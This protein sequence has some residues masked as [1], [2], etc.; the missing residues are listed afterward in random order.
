[1]RLTTDFVQLGDIRSTIMKY[2]IIRET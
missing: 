2:E 1:M